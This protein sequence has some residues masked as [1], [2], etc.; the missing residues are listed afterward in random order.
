MFRDVIAAEQFLD[1]DAGEIFTERRG[2]AEQHGGNFSRGN[3]LINPRLRFEP[4]HGRDQQAIH[5]A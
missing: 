1:L 2:R 4:I 5:A 3:L